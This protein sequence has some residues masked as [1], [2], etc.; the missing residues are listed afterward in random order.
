M[1]ATLKKQKK[2]TRDEFEER[3]KAI[4]VE[5]AQQVRKLPFFTR[6]HITG[7]FFL[8]LPC[9]YNQASTL[10]GTGSVSLW[11]AFSI[12]HS[13]LFSILLKFFFFKDLSLQSEFLTLKQTLVK[14]QADLEGNCFS[15]LC[16]GH[17]WSRCWWVI[18][19]MKSHCSSSLQAS[20]LEAFPPSLACTNDF[21]FYVS[22]GWMQLCSM[23]IRIPALLCPWYLPL[24]TLAMAWEVWS[25]FLSS[26]LRPCWVRGL[27]SVRSWEP[28]WWR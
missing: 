4:I 22:R 2:N 6:D 27:P 23:R 3:A 19:R 26:W 21:A 12:F 8:L 24:H 18:L 28:R 25:A 13:F 9:L 11:M 20:V 5:F 15:V 10:I 16:T 7:D 17:M 1:A 14:H